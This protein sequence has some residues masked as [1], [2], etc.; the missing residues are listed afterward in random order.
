MKRFFISSTARFLEIEKIIDDIRGEIEKEE[1]KPSNSPPLWVFV[2]VIVGL[3]I[4]LFVVLY[5]SNT[6]PELIYEISEIPAMKAIFPVVPS[7][8]VG[9]PKGRSIRKARKKKIL[10]L[11]EKHHDHKMIVVQW[12]KIS[13]PRSCDRFIKIKCSK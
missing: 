8:V 6:D 13:R 5:A 1:K 11:Q 2:S 10:E 4:F 7:F 9:F 3:F 12:K